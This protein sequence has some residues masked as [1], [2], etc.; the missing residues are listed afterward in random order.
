MAAT[1][2]VRL[3]RALTVAFIQVQFRSLGVQKFRSLEVYICKESLSCYLDSLKMAA[4]YSPTNAVPSALLS[5]TTL[6]GMGRGG[7]SAL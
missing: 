6:F 2:R 7:T 1:C 4:T 5:L 3:S